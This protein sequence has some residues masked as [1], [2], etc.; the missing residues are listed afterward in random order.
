[1]LVCLSLLLVVSGWGK[2]KIYQRFSWLLFRLFLILI[3]F[4]LQKYWGW[5]DCFLKMRIL[6]WLFLQSCT[7]QTVLYNTVG[8]WRVSTIEFGQNLGKN[9]WP[10][11]RCHPVAH[12]YLL[13]LWAACW[14]AKCTD[15]FS[16]AYSGV[17]GLPYWRWSMLPSNTCALKNSCCPIC[18]CY[19]PWYMHQPCYA[20]KEAV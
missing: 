2:T 13:F 5:G 20:T 9:Q 6:L 3:F 7:V 18:A 8:I 12:W 1:M 15:M 10:D 11:W 14:K 17:L 16:L 19:R 4:C